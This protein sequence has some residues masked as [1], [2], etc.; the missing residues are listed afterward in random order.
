[1]EVLDCIWKC[2]TVY[3]GVVLQAKEESGAGKTAEDTRVEGDKTTDTPCAT[4]SAPAILT[5]TADSTL[6]EIEARLIGGS[7]LLSSVRLYLSHR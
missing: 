1:M 3:G 6:T 7:C 2:W 4:E 5:L